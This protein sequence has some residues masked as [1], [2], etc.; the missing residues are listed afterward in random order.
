MKQRPILFSTPMVQ[1]IPPGRKTQTRRTKG[2]DYINSLGSSITWG[3]CFMGEEMT[4]TPPCPPGLHAF[5]GNPDTD[6]WYAPIKCPYGQPGDILWVRETWKPKYV[7][8]GLYGF[9][10]QYP[11]VHPWFYAAEGESEKG[12]GRWKPS[13][14]MPR[15]AARIFLRITDIRVER[16]QDITEEDAMAEGAEPM[17]HRCGGFGYYEAG[18][19]IMDCACQSWDQ[20]EYG[21][22]FKWL[23]QSINGPESWTANPWV[24]VVSFEKV[25]APIS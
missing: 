7:K 11:D 8:G 19:E 13:I 6:E 1:A 10:L 16:L 2:L 5:F 12:Y 4:Y 15:E 17:N 21:M 9:R 20:G 22:G 14:H 24:W 23:W 3:K 25:T 18:G